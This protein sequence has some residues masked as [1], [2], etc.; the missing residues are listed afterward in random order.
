MRLAAFLLL[1][2]AFAGCFHA[3]DRPVVYDAPRWVAGEEWTMLSHD[4]M[5]GVA[6]ID[7]RALGPGPN[8]TWQL[9]VTAAGLPGEV[10]FAS[11]ATMR[12]DPDPRVAAKPPAW[13]WPLEEGET[14][15]AGNYTAVVRLEAAQTETSTLAAARVTFSNETGPVQ[16]LWYAPQAKF[17]ARVVDHPT[18]TA[19][20]L[21]AYKIS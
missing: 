1:A 13:P 7:Y 17:W 11:P 10:V 21:A 19:T 8:G 6:R 12:F 2:A 5:G 20:V 15:Q 3:K 4:L 16:D 14:W 18:S 9:R